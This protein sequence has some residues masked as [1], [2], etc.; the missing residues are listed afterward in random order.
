MADNGRAWDNIKDDWTEQTPVVLSI[1][2]VQTDSA[3]NLYR[4]LEIAVTE[5]FISKK[6]MMV[7]IGCISRILV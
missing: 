5:G 1:G 2:N 6:G 4:D 7:K 3:N